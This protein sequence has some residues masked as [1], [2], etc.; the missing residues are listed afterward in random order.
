MWV[1]DP[2]VV[3]KPCCVQVRGTR[4]TNY[5][6]GDY[7]G[8]SGFV[9]SVSDPR[10]ALETDV[11]REANVHF[12]GDDSGRVIAFPPE[13]L[14]PIPP[15]TP[16]DLV[17]VL[18]GPRKGQELVMESVGTD[19]DATCVVSSVPPGVMFEIAKDVLVQLQKR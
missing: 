13:Y 5:R 14:V 18:H 12:D 2:V 11:M 17:L 15:R 1:F 8:R 7:E 9:V 16:K 4:I 19:D 10:T 6:R 3:G